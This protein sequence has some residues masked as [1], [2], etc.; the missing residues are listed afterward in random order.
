MQTDALITCAVQAL[1]NKKA[2]DIKV[3]KVGDFTVLADSFLLATA[4]SFPHLHA[5]EEEVTQRLSDAG[6]QPQHI[7]GRSTG[8][9]LLD[10]GS[11]IIHLFTKEARAFYALDTMW[12]D[13]PSVDLS[14][15][16]KS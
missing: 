9:L 4:T 14:T 8:W 11:V 10:Y 2:S 7:E 13:A 12:G 16:I 3:L 5:L 15:I 6:L 1:D